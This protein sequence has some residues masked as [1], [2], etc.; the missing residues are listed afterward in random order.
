MTERTTALA[1]KL[2]LDDRDS[3][4]RD[5]AFDFVDARKERDEARTRLTF[6]HALDE[7]E[8]DGLAELAKFFAARAAA[9]EVKP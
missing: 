8:P 5:L 1:L 7:L 6:I 3:R 2:L 4:V 9:E